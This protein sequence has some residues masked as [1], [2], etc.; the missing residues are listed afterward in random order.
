M[1]RGVGME[2][3]CVMCKSHLRPPEGPHAALAQPE[4]KYGRFAQDRSFGAAPNG[5]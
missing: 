1:L 4:N 3:L 5:N 2:V